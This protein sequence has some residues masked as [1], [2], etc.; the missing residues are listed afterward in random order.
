[1]WWKIRVIPIQV[2]SY[3]CQ[4]SSLQPNYCT[5]S[6]ISLVPMNSLWC[7]CPIITNIILYGLNQLRLLLFDGLASHLRLIS[8][9]MCYQTHLQYLRKHEKFAELL[10]SYRPHEVRYQ[11]N[12]PFGKHV[13]KDIGH[14]FLGIYS[15][16][17][18]VS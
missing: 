1:M 11:W 17:V 8:Q 6:C 10:S 5:I 15:Y 7:K 14:S 3:H 13:G 4:R 9:L 16:V 18:S 12:Y 2:Y